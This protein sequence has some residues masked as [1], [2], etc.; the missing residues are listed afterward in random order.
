MGTVFGCPAMATT[1]LPGRPLLAPRDP[2]A[3]GRQL[4]RALAAIHLNALT[5]ID[6]G[7]LP[8]LEA[9]LNTM[10]ASE[11]SRR[12]VAE[13]PDGESVWSA[14]QRCRPYP[15]VVSSTLVH[16]DYWV[17][18]TLWQGGRLTGVVDWSDAFL[19]DPA[20]DVGYCRTGLASIWWA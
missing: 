4:A 11:S 13:H 2:I 14:L 6:V 17:G 12:R 3:W 20:A 15:P 10:L 18:N 19:G 7:F 5:G 8:C 1:L 16:G 9:W